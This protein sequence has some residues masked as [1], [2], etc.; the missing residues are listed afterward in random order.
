MGVGGG[1][2]IKVFIFISNKYRFT[3]L[4]W[5]AS[6]SFQEELFPVCLLSKVF[7]SRSYVS[8]SWVFEN[9][10]SKSLPT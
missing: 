6:H 8:G 10:F 4:L 5:E 7:Y 2:R 1:A 3:I 9:E